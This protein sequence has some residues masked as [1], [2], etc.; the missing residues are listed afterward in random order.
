M[1][2][3]PL[4]QTAE[5][6][7][8]ARGAEADALFAADAFGAVLRATPELARLSSA[9]AALGA[10]APAQTAIEAFNGR[11]QELRLE[12]SFGTITPDQRAELDRLQAALLAVPTVSAYL[13]AQTA[14]EELCRE[15][16]A[17]I[18]AEIGIDFAANCRMSSCCGG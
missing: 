18:S 3:Q 11:E 1:A 4:D 5:F 9:H 13:A 7:G 15:T 12:L 16:A 8:A 6:E 2:I 17:L 14:L 10:D